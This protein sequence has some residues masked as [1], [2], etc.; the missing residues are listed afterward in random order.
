ML[1]G[2]RVF[3]SMA[4][5]KTYTTKK[6]SIDYIHGNDLVITGQFIDFKKNLVARYNLWSEKLGDKF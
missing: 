1:R 3:H 2:E 4:P 6:H 5:S